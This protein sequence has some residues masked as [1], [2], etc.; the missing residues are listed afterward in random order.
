MKRVYTHIDTNNKLQDDISQNY[1][2]ES[3]VLEEP[4]P[5]FADKQSSCMKGHGRK[6]D[7]N[8]PKVAVLSSF[9]MNHYK[10]YFMRRQN[11][12]RCDFI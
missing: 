5:D 11:Y 9:E 2:V 7:Y 4:I 1:G 6:I 12:L 8:G 3:I 10:Q